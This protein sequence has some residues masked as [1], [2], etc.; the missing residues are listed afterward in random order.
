MNIDHTTAFDIHRCFLGDLD[1]ILIVLIQNQHDI[2]KEW[3]T[4]DLLHLMK[5]C[6]WS[7]CFQWQQ[8]KHDL[9][10]LAKHSKCETLS[11]CWKI[12]CHCRLSL[13]VLLMLSQ[14]KL[15]APIYRTQSPSKFWYIRPLFS[16]K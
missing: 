9:N 14:K 2:L 5:N 6:H 10:T 11:I 3:R 13:S 4:S 7:T 16:T 8:Q 12:T 15:P 1:V